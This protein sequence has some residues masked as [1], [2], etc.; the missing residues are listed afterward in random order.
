MDT[1]AFDTHQKALQINLDSSVYGVFAEIG[2]GQE[3][4]RWFFRVGGAAGTIAKTIS[5]YDMTVSDAIYGPCE[6]YVSR[7]RLEKMLSHEYSILIDRLAGKKGGSTRFFAFADTVVARSYSRID[8]THGWMGIRFQHQLGA[9]PSQI[10]IHVSML[11]RDGIAQQEAL[12]VMGVNLVH[13]AFNHHSNS[14]ALV[15]SLLDNLTRDRVEVDLIRLTGPAFHGIDNRLMSLQLVQ[16][17]LTNA[18]MI[19]ADGEVV[20][21]AD[22]LHKKPILV[23]RG[24]FRPVTK[25]M[26]DMLQCSLAQFVQESAVQ[27]DD[28]VVLM[29]MTLNNLIHGD[30]IDHKDFLARADTLGAL[31]K[32]VLISNFD[33]FYR[34]AA[35]LFRFN[36]K[37]IG[38]AIGVPTLK[39][40]FNEK[41]YKQL[42]GGILESFGRLFENALR[43][44]AYP[45]RDT[46]TGALI[47]AANLLVLPHLRNL[48]AYL[49]EN[50]YI[51]SIRGF[52]ES[53]LPYYSGAV[54][55]KLEAGETGWEEMVPQPVAN[56]IKQRQLWG[57]RGP[58][59]GSSR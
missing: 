43:V 29:E 9:E 19:A 58:G 51:E 56:I 53:L 15:L 39:E 38:I 59:A 40:I 33:L 10:V 23:L 1:E 4:A 41:Y 11:E 21:P 16:K 54:L 36:S 48:Y 55:S 50:C 52:D 37:M 44:Y 2:A 26:M 46:A 25:T 3:V 7:Q 22:V 13:A 49:H 32:T 17:G 42:P 57:Y 14:D 5:A 6:R 45:Q 34:L 24:N 28:V 12:G 8:D 27:G 35:Y 18:A 31:G 20:Q 30:G 47:T